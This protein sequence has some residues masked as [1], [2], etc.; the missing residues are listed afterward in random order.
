M[1]EHVLDTNVLLFFV[2]GHR[3]LPRRAARLIEDPARRSVVSMAS[4]W[5]ISIK[6]GLGK[7]RFEHADDPDLPGLLRAKGFDVQ[8]VSWAVMRRA[9][10]LPGEHRDPF[11]RYLAAEALSRGAPILS[12]DPKLDLFGV[13]RIG[14]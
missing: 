5:E 1:N 7:L 6:S 9:S 13:E 14:D 11:D 8:P 10:A 12:T 2:Q 3:G 4:L